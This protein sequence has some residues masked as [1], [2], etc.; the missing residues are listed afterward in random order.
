MIWGLLPIYTWR[1]P[2]FIS[3]TPFLNNQF[4]I[5]SLPCGIPKTEVGKF[6][7]RSEDEYA[8]G[9]IICCRYTLQLYHFQFKEGEYFIDINDFYI[10]N[11]CIS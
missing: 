3:A 5:I 1:P 6:T 8:C 2:G 10:A 7:E 4:P 11:I 9:R